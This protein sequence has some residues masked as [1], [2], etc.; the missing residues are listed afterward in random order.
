MVAPRLPPEIC[1]VGSYA[2]ELSRAWPKPT[3]TS[4]LVLSGVEASRAAWP[5]ENI[6]GFSPDTGEFERLL[7]L[8]PDRNVLLHYAGR[9]YHRFGFPFW[10]TGG[11]ARWKAKDP[12]RRLH[13]IFH[14]LPAHLSLL[15][16]QGFLQG[17]GFRISRRLA[18]Q[19]DTLITNSEHHAELLR[20]WV[21]DTEV[22]WFP[23]PS[24]IRPA[25]ANPFSGERRRGEFVIFGLPFSRLQ[26]IQLFRDSI[27]AWGKTGR[28]RVLHLVGPRDE[29]FSAQADDILAQCLPPNAIVQHGAL[30]AAEISL[31]LL[32]AEFCLSPVTK[33]TWSKSSSFMAFAAHGCPIVSMEQTSSPPLHETIPPADVATITETD[34]RQ[35][36]GALREWYSRNADW[37]VTAKR[38]A[39]LISEDRFR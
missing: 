33:L 1:G 10:M 21:G 14:E 7:S 18:N 32:G 29:K 31:R 30:P 2:W 15:S 3:A 26:T 6:H 8:Q 4:W 34:A 25:T 36:A 22:Y 39:A 24:N 35:K 38:I 12:G 28:L 20:S 5:N 13:V 17:L 19:A 16:R 11:F 37:D 27:S 9:A 23:V